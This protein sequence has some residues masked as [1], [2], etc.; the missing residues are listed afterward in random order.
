M[1]TRR[2]TLLVFSQVFV[3]DPASVGQHMADVAFEMARRGHRVVVYA[4]RR[5]YE[6]PSVRYPARE[7][8]NGVD[9]RR[10]AFASFGKRN[11]MVRA[12]GTL[13]FI[14]QCA[15][16][17]LFTRNLGGVFFSTSPPLVGGAA[18]LVKIVRGVPIAYWAMDLNPDQLIA[19]G[20]IRA[21]SVTARVL[22]R[23]NRFLLGHSSLVIPLDRFMA[24]RIRGRGVPDARL[25]VIPPWPHESHLEGPAAAAEGAANPFRQRHGLE[26]KFVVMYSGNHSPANPL[27]TLLEA[28]VRLRERGDVQFLFVGGGLGKREV[29]AYIR[30]HGLGNVTSLPYQP[31]AELGHSLGAADLHVV[32]LGEAM[33]GI[34]HPCKIYGA[35]AVGRPV[36]FLGPEPSH[37][38]DLL[39][40]H[41]I[42]WH[43]SHGDVEGAVGAVEA[44]AAT[45][46]ARRGAMGAE[47][48]RVLHSG[49]GQA[50]LCGRLCDHLEQIFRSTT[51]GA[52]EVGT[53]S[54]E[55]EVSCVR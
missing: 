31:L 17:A 22:E 51:A 5:G 18:A 4:A 34:I 38:A 24:E 11:L 35:M 27:T 32:S 48:R 36:L 42:G 37:I 40:H 16:R 49:L 30:E 1:D 14:L 9:V 52:A 21:R 53:A 26:G 20:K 55:R 43:V 41:D 50:M 47:A 46:A 45:P 39:D 7:M 29:E 19:M 13:M 33:V 2:K 15:V 3:P 10:L 12:F 54:A 8:L 6:D 44:A 28:A 23:I 25:V